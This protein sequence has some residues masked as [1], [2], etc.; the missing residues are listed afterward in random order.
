MHEIYFP[1]KSILHKVTV[2]SETIQKPP[3]IFMGSFD[4]LCST[5]VVQFSSSPA[6]T[7][8]RKKICFELTLLWTT[9]SV[10]T[11]CMLCGQWTTR[12][13]QA[14]KASYM[15]GIFV[16]SA[17]Q[18][19]LKNVMFYLTAVVPCKNMAL[20]PGQSGLDKGHCG[21]GQNK[22]R[23]NTLSPPTASHNNHFSL[24]SFTKKEHFISICK[25]WWVNSVTH[26]CPL[27]FYPS[28]N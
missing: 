10:Y 17:R 20:V 23:E 19:T 16:M 25:A 7:I 14:V 24:F 8:R 13:S 9:V 3:H 5:V 21:R 1:F 11:I 28:H 4:L 26:W 27:S 18:E 2:D 12:G 6:I 22:T 15:E